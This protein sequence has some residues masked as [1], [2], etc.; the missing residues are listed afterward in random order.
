[1]NYWNVTIFS[2]KALASEREKMF[3]FKGVDEDFLNKG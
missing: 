3:F 1:M 2:G